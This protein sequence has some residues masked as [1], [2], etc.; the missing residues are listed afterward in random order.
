MR[1]KDS[2]ETYSELTYTLS[3]TLVSNQESLEETTP[4]DETVETIE[5]ISLEEVDVGFLFD[6]TFEWIST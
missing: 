5:I 6:F 3:L 1:L 2:N 4:N